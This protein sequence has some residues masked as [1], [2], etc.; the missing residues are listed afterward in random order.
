M[1]SN[2]IF[3]YGINHDSAPIEF[4]ER[5]AFD[6]TS[7]QAV[8]EQI[9]RISENRP[10]LIFK[11]STRCAISSMVLNKFENN[12]AEETNFDRYFLDLIT[13]RSVS[14]EVAARYGVTHQSP[15]AILISKGQAVYEASHSGIVYEEIAKRASEVQ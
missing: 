11:H 12:L 5:L 14:N 4:R 9:D 2:N 15:Q 6:A 1:I 7:R 13:Y 10:V 3:V 8:L